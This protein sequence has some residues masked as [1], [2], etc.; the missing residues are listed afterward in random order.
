MT[1]NSCNQLL[2][3]GQLLLKQSLLNKSEQNK[4]TFNGE[5]NNVIRTETSEKTTATA[6]QQQKKDS[7][8]KTDLMKKFSFLN[9]DK[10]YLSRL[11]TYVNKNFA[12]HNQHLSIGNAGGDFTSF[13]KPVSCIKPRT[14]NMVFSTLHNSDEATKSAS[15]MKVS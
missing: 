9:R 12:G 4:R 3:K 6:T 14:N 2:K 10:S 11:S 13:V 7:V 8:E 1:S 15:N 5:I